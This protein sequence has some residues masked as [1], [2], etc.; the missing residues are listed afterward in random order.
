MPK[1]SS[2]KKV[3]SVPNVRKLLKQ[4]AVAAGFV[5]PLTGRKS[6]G[7]LTGALPPQIPPESAVDSEVAQSPPEVAPAISAPGFASAVS[8]PVDEEEFISTMRGNP[9]VS[10]SGQFDI[11]CRRV[12]KASIPSGD[13]I[14]E[15]RFC[16]IPLS[17]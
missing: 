6:A 9:I 15:V 4:S 1:N 13:Q 2:P 16:C 17:I 14:K 12:S 8:L 10:A 5:E 11:L 3:P 7:K